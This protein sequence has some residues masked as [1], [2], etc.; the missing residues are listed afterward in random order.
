MATMSTC[1][2]QMARQYPSSS[3]QHLHQHQHH[4]GAGWSTHVWSNYA[5]SANKTKEILY[6]HTQHNDV[7]MFVR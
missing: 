3:T 7:E 5:T 4:K 2:M 1:T 6:T